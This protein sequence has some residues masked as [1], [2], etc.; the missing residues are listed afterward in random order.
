MLYVEELD[1]PVIEDEQRNLAAKISIAQKLL[2]QLSEQMTEPLGTR[3]VRPFTTS[4]IHIDTAWRSL[5]YAIDV[6]GIESK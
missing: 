4:R 6:L 2:S 5:Q 3:L 1:R